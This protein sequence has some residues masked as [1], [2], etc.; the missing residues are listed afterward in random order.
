MIVIMSDEVVERLL[1][2]PGLEQEL[3]PKQFLFHRGD[4]VRHMHVVRK[5]DIRLVRHLEDGAAIVLQRARAG[6]IVAEA[7][8]FSSAYHCDG[9]AF[10]PTRLKSI[11]KE[12]VTQSLRKGHALFEAFTVHLAKEVQQARM[13]SEILTLKTVAQRLDAWL[14]WN[15]GMLP[16]KGNWRS[17]AMEIGVSPEALYR[18]MAK[19][20]P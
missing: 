2:L 5:G 9:L 13:R 12:T 1:E 3:G 7:S 20:R 15:D 11:P 8:L 4:A 6:S 19:R 10:A 17:V 16:A 14:A 18:E